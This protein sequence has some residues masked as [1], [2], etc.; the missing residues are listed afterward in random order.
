MNTEEDGEGI[1]ILNTS[2]THSYKRRNLFN[3]SIIISQ[4]KKSDSDSNKD[5]KIN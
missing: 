4:G 1:G 3:K 5:E 2:K